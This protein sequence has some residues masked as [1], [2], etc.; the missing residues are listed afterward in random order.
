MRFFNYFLVELG[1]TT[2]THKLKRGVAA[3]TGGAKS[4]IKAVSFQRDN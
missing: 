2:P 1:E 4:R 3:L